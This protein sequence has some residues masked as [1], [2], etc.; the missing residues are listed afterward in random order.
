[1]ITT[2]SADFCKVVYISKSYDECVEKAVEWQADV[3]VFQLSNPIYKT[4][5]FF[6]DLAETKL[7][8]VLLAFTVVSHNEIIYSITSHHDSC[9]IDKLANYFTNALR[10]TYDC[11][12][13]Y[14]GKE[15]DV[16]N[17]M[18]TRIK[19]LEK[20]EYL[21][22]ILRGVTQEEFFYYKRKGCLN[23]RDSGYY[24]YLY[25]IMDIEYMDHDLNKNIYY[26]VGEK[27]I[28]ECKGVLDIY[29]GGEVFYINPTLLCIIINDI[30]CKSQ[31]LYQ[32]S[33]MELVKKLNNIV[34][35]ILKM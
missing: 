20:T 11:H 15:K 23:L 14:I 7:S 4:Q 19:K 12:F 8:P 34:Y 28:D 31:A 16:D 6:V 13:N 9:L 26:L 25:N 5:N 3:I 35:G 21:N 27:L 10:N 29:N 24:L 18:T 17:I 32:Q 2:Y 1:M 30:P 33:I 22:D